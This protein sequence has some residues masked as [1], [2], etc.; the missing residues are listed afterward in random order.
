MRIVTAALGA[1]G[2]RISA[3]PSLGGVKSMTGGREIRTAK[4]QIAQCDAGSRTGA[5]C[6]G[7]ARDDEQHSRC[8]WPHDSQA[9]PGSATM[10]RV[11]PGTMTLSQSA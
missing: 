1:G 6:D 2:S 8:A 10:P 7:S 9:A 5:R 3:S 4:K 11:C